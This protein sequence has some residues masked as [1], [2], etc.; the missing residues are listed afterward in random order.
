MWLS[1]YTTN[2]YKKQ[3]CAL[4]WEQGDKNSIASKTAADPEGFRGSTGSR[5]EIEILG[6]WA[7]W[8]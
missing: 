2:E 5:S 6:M 1:N 8:S 3:N 7:T 4:K